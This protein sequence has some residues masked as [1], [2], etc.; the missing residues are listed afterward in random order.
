ME[1]LELGGNSILLKLG[2]KLTKM[3]AK[4]TERG[5]KIIVTNPKS[6]LHSPH[7]L[8]INFT[9]GNTDKYLLTLEGNYKEKYKERNEET[10]AIPI[11]EMFILIRDKQDKWFLK[12]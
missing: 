3:G 2:K 11:E 6:K 7:L 10:D 4:Y 1:K 12:K 9:V 8:T 5:S